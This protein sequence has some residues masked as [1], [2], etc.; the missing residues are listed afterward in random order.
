MHSKAQ[1]RIDYLL[2]HGK[3]DFIA[4]Y[5][6]WSSE[7]SIYSW[8]QCQPST[9]FQTTIGSIYLTQWRLQSNFYQ[10]IS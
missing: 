7:D 1:S 8:I 5:T 3:G 6:P 4:F 10:L 9:T 2:D